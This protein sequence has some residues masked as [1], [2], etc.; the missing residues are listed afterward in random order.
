MF[1]DQYCTELE[2]SLFSFTREQ[3]SAFAKD[4][5]NDFNPLHDVDTKKFCVPGDL[6]FARILMSEGLYSNMRVNF[7]GM[8]SDGVA[9]HIV[10]GDNGDKII[11]DQKEKEYL[12]IEHSG[13]QNTDRALI[14]KLIKAYVAFSG[15]NFPHVLVPLMK[16]Q[17]VMINVSRPLVIYESMSVHLSSV[18]LK[19]PEIEASHAYL[20]VNG[21]RG[22]V[23]LGFVF[24]DNGV[25]V[26]EGKKTMVLAN[27]REFDQEVMDNLVAQ[28]IKR[29]EAY[30]Q[31]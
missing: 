23:T 7:S 27:L 15:E 8:V 2:D 4:I 17:N 31:S 25:V 5:A 14:E 26:G 13:D 24:K 6:L 11:C 16:E 21:K 9:L 20:D 18:D 12:R 3:S 1:L 29:R 10:T 30:H 22:N 19:K 28:F